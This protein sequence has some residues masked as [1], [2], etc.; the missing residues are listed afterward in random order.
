LKYL[1]DKI[2][3]L[4]KK[5]K[6]IVIEDIVYYEFMFALKPDT[7]FNSIC[8]FLPD[9]TLIVGSMSKTFRATGNRLGYLLISNAA[10]QM[11]DNQFRIEICQFSDSQTFID[12][13]KILK[14][15]DKCGAFSHTHLVPRISQ[16]LGAFRLIFHLKDNESY[17]KHIKERW[18]VFNDIMGLNSN[19]DSVPYYLLVD[20]LSLIK[21]EATKNNIPV[22]E[23]PD[24]TITINNKVIH[25][26]GFITELAKNGVIGLP[27]ARFFIGNEVNNLW[28]VR[29]SISNSDI[30]QVTEAANIINSCISDLCE[31]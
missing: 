24:H 22:R 3:E 4:N 11:L 10:A 18:N 28:K 1:A 2:K 5:Q 27:A 13:F 26:S 8:E 23:N 25:A 6:V 9:Q 12:L 21:N 7:K 19:K 31:G 16:W 30:Q 20:F 17:F 29:F 14:A 15:P